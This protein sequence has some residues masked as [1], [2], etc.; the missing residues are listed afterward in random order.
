MLD[1][2]AIVI[3]VALV[4]IALIYVRGCDALKGKRT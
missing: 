3:L 1:V 4:A 2:L